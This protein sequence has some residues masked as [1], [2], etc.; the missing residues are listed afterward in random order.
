MDAS[1]TGKQNP[2]PQGREVRLA[3]LQRQLKGTQTSINHLEQKLHGLLNDDFMGFK[4]SY[5]YL[6]EH[7][8][9]ESHGP[10][11]DGLFMGAE[12]EDGLIDGQQLRR[13]VYFKEAKYFKQEN[14][15]ADRVAYKDGRREVID[16]D[17]FKFVMAKEFH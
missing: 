1:D 11:N 17:E 8:I 15:K 7:Y 2:Y 12:K 9:H 16:I 5:E 14:K 4:Q 6:D 10:F 13:T 3:Q